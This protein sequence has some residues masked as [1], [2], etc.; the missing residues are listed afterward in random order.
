MSGKVT[1]GED[2]IRPMATDF[3]KLCRWRAMTRHRL[4]GNRFFRVG[5]FESSRHTNFIESAVCLEDSTAPYELPIS[6]LDNR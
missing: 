3:G 6:K 2:A 1:R 5:V 4:R